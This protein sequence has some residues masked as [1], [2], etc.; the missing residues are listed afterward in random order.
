M[1][2]AVLIALLTAAGAAAQ[3]G[4]YVGR[5]VADVL[6]ELQ[7]DE[8]RIIFS[9]DLV[10]P[11]MRVKAEP[12]KQGAREIAQQVLAAHGLALKKGPQNTWTVVR[13]PQPPARLTSP[14]VSDVRPTQTPKT[15][16]PPPTPPVRIEEQVE[17][18][19]RLRETAN[20][21]A[22]Y[23]VQQAEVRELAGGFDNVFQMMQVL[24]GAAGINDEEGK[25]AVRG[26]GPEHNLIVVDDLQIHRP[27]RLGH[28]TAS[29]LNPSTIERVSLDASGLD[30]R[31]GQR[32]SSVTVIDTRDGTR[33]RK[34][35]VSG[36]L[37]L[38]AGDILAEGRLP[39]T[40]SGSWWVTTRGTYYRPLLDRF[41]DGVTP[42]FSDVQFKVAARPSSRTRLTVF[43]LAG[44]ETLR[45]Y[46]QMSIDGPDVLNEEYRGDNRLGVA[47]LAWTPSERLMATTSISAY[48]NDERDYGG[49][50]WV[51]V[52]PFERVTQVH[53][54]AARQRFVY[55]PSSNHLLD[56]GV[57]LRRVRST[58]RMASVKQPEFWRGLGPS[59]WGERI[60]YAAGPIDTRLTRTQVGFW[61]QDRIALGRNMTVEPGLRVDWNSYTGESALQP[62][63]RLSARIGQTIVWTGLAL[64]AQTPSHESL[65]GLDYFH[66]SPEI[67]RSLENE[68]SRQVVVGFERRLRSDLALRV[69][70]Y[71]RR[72]DNLLVQRLESDAERAAR[73][74]LYDL[75]AD[76]PADAVVLEHRPT[77]H[78]ESTGT[79]K[80]S[81]VEVLLQ[82]EG[83]KLSGW[84]TYSLSKSTRELYGH[85]VPFDFDRR[86]ALSV[87]GL[88]QLSRRLR[89]SVTWQMA[90]GFPVTPLHEEVSFGQVVDLTK[91]FLIDPTYRAA[92][93]RNGALV[94]RLDPFM[95]RLALRNS[96]RLSGYGRTDIR[97]TFATLGHWEFYGEVIN[98]FNQR[99]YLIEVTFPA[100][101]NLPENISRSNIYAEFDRIPTAGLRFRF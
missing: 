44:R 77:V 80:A 36:S 85:E 13:L 29:F 30:A 45:S 53:D 67:G 50:F 101:Q 41:E 55:S 51:G 63:V 83:R 4:V 38:V 42:G 46:E 96:D 17:V 8:F 6:R 12:G 87:A 79:G 2:C 97:V 27:Q 91:G 90:S 74:A 60:D 99:N 58:W 71:H 100:T 7:T 26:A 95:R 70:A 98:L 16:E 3:S 37:G 72:F 88:A 22:S 75:P 78:P 28:F 56:G 34:L 19:D 86:H 54:Y 62:R 25:L 15:E 47:S 94:T 73:L 48:A 21:G 40:E 1:L 65:Q 43:G 14:P 31:F 57:E 35:A 59:T 69:E 20:T 32:L 92:R 24:P 76:L 68:R 82:R 49:F 11:S 89:A 39:G 93:D 18:V 33:D 64:Q 61:L 84:I 52:A 66:L 5:P 10:P 23:T 81:G 9:S